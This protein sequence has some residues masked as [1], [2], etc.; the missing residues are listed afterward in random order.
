MCGLF[1]LLSQIRFSE[2]PR[3]KEIRGSIKASGGVSL[4]RY[5]DERSDAALFHCTGWEKKSGGDAEEFL[6]TSDITTD[7]TLKAKSLFTVERG[8][9]KVLINS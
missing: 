8:T 7:N 9:K 4:E 5:T 1:P 2:S 6:S 3:T